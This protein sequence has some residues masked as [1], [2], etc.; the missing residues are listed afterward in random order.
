MKAKKK[1]HYKNATCDSQ[2]HEFLRH[3][4]IGNSIDVPP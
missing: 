3:D 2:R 4:E 1:Y